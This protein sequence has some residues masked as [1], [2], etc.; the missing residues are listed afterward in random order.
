MEPR[1]PGMTVRARA[2]WPA[3]AQLAITGALMAAAG[4]SFQRVFGPGPLVPVLAVAAIGPAALSLACSGRP[5]WAAIAGSGAC[6]FAVV[7]VT[8]LRHTAIAGV[9]PTAETVATAR[10]DVSDGWWQMLTTILPAPATAGMLLDVHLVVWAGTAAASEV[11]LRTRRTLPALLPAFGIL[12]TGLAFGVDGPGSDVWPAAAVLLFAGLLAVARNPGAPSRTARQIL[13]GIALAIVVAVGAAAA[14][15]WL[16]LA[17][18]RTPFDPRRYVHPAARDLVLTSPL[19]SVSLWLSEPR[20]RLFQVVAPAPEDWRLAVLDT[21]DGQ[22]WTS[23]GSFTST[24]GRVPPPGPGDGGPGDGGPGDGGAVTQTVTIQNLTGPWLPAAGRPT[25]VTGVPVDVDPSSGVLLSR[26]GLSAGLRYRVVSTPADPGVS[27]LRTAAVADDA[28]ARA[29][30][31]LPPDAP[32]V[33][34]STAQAA[35]A[36]AAFPFQQAVLLGSY[37]YDHEEFDPQ[38]PP[39]HSYGAIGYFLSTSHRGTSE[40]FAVAYV[41][42]A[43]SLGLPARLVVGFRPGTQIAPGTWQVLGEDALVWPEVDFAGVGW[44]AFFPTPA[45]AGRHPAGGVPAGQSAAQHNLDQ[46]LGSAKPAAPRQASGPGT[47]PR[48]SSRV[49]AT[50]GRGPSAGSMAAVAAL[51]IALGYLGGVCGLPVW[52]RRRRRRGDPAARIAGAWAETLDCLRACGFRPSP[53]HSAPEIALLG[54][55]HLGPSGHPELAG[56]AG[57]TDRALFAPAPL[58]DAAA[59]QAWRHCDAVRRMARARSPWY[60]RLV[61]RL[62]P[63]VLLS[64]R[65]RP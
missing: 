64:A 22:S 5:L 63:G 45:V 26:A 57:L 2:G 44:V 65:W 55:A 32:R 46:Q 40:Q 8:L 52:R 60:R 17:S 51:A 33:I 9:V 19:D 29:D 23:A 15:P 18:A 14:E 11:V 48:R 53:A 39:G 1:N 13:S 21:F 42:M 10:S 35:T 3:V 43:R 37:L 30:L 59:R 7:T 62:R 54:A 50:P 24:G 20:L 49:P 28:A 38:A 61:P 58:D 31:A 36:G 34:A 41:L 16:P 6:W 27:R 4:A 56:L 12:V 47:Q 25:V